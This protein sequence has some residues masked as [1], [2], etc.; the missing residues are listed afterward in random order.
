[1]ERTICLSLF[2]L[3]GHLLFGGFLLLFFPTEGLRL[4][5]ANGDY[6]TVLPRVVG[7]LLAGLGS[8][9]FAI[10]RTRSEATYRVRQI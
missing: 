1:M 2:Y 4:S 8:I 9:V 7:M 5:L 6:G 10:I 3:C